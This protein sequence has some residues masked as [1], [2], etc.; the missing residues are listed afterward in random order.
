[1][2]WNG[3]CTLA[4]LG[5]TFLP[6]AMPPEGQEIDFLSLERVADAALANER[7]GFTWQGLTINFGAQMRTYLGDEL[8]L[9]TLI[10]WTDGGA[11]TSQTVGAGLDRV[12]AAE[13]QAG[14]LSS[15]NIRITM[16]EASV[17]LAN[18]GQTAIIHRTDGPIGSV[19]INTGDNVNARTEVV[20]QLDISGFEPFRADLARQHIG[21]T[22]GDMVGHAATGA[23]GR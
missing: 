15:G 1:M 5:L 4:L 23:L 13:L 9:E 7:G 16:G 6:A 10:S 19:L 8:A 2:A 12:S 17:F 3:K 14:I 22:L 20:A 21:T 11:V 18:E